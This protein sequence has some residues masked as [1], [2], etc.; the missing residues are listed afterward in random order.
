MDNLIIVA[1]QT[2]GVVTF[3]NYD[4]VKSN[5]QQYISENFDTANYDETGVEAA[6]SDYEELKKMRD[7]VTKKQK[8]LEKAY[9]I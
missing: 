9:D 3:D 5:L 6:N 8:E 1:N 7:V 4:E 2:P